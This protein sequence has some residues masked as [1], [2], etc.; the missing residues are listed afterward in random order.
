M[1]FNHKIITFF[2]LE[3]F[4]FNG[5]YISLIKINWICKENHIFFYFTIYIFIILVSNQIPM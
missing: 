1:K 2:N 5:G 4:N 3:F